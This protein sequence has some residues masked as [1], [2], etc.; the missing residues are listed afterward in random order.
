MDT[1]LTI[2]RRIVNKKALFAADLAHSY[3]L[4]QKRGLTTKGVVVFYYGFGVL[5][6]ICGILLEYARESYLP[7][8]LVLFIIAF[9]TYLVVKLRLLAEE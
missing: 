8:F 5:L 6:G 7:V 2:I 4:V 9:F 3:N 1:V